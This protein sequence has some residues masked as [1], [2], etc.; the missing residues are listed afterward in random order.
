MAYSVKFFAWYVLTEIILASWALNIDEVTHKNRLCMNE[1][2]DGLGLADSFTYF[3]TRL[4][5][6]HTQA[7]RLHAHKGNGVILGPET[8]GSTGV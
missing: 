3:V 8:V 1:M 2:V 7:F 4:Q 5:I 6:P